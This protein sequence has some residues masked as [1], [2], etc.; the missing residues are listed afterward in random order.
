MELKSNL[1]LCRFCAFIFKSRE[2]SGRDFFSPEK[3]EIYHF[4]A[5]SDK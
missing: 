4:W 2:S 1:E 5:Y 3:F